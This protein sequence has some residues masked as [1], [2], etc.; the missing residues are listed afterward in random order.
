VTHLAAVAGS[1]V[2]DA[3][4]FCSYCGRLDADTQRVCSE[5]G[6][7]VRLQ[8]SR[9]V[10]RSPGA[11]FLVVRA[12]GS[13]SAASAAAERMLGVHG[14][15]VGKPLMTLVTTPEA[16]G[17]LVRAVALAAAGEPEAHEFDVQLFGT[18][19]RRA[20]VRATVASCGLPPA[21]LVLLERA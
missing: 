14:E 1:H 15:L 21:A 19:K 7:G 6:L 12:D 3:V 20:T 5:C 13:V 18:A 16:G 11:A 8:T 17:G 10:L 2:D 4:G 9:E